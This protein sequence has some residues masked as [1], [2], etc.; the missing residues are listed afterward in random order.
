MSAV[1]KVGVGIRVQRRPFLVVR[2]VTGFVRRL[3]S[4]G[5]RGA[6]WITQAAVWRH[7]ST[8]RRGIAC[9]ICA[10]HK[11]K[12]THRNRQVASGLHK[13]LSPTLPLPKDHGN[14]DDQD[15]NGC[16]CPNDG[17]TSAAT[18]AASGCNLLFILVALLYGLRGIT[19][20]QESVIALVCIGSLH[21][22]GGPVSPPP[23]RITV[24]QHT[25][26]EGLCFY[27]RHI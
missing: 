16:N 3:G 9:S 2:V 1:L 26:F 20:G 5:V 23:Q 11:M 15:D 8:I 27:I 22:G 19:P 12:T 7:V 17:A 13:H 24:R 18:A 4:L 10:I 25:H 14:D 21:E 6:A